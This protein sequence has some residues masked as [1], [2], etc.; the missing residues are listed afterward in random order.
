MILLNFSHQ[1]SSSQFDKIERLLSTNIDEVISISPQI[2]IKEHFMEQIHK[3]VDEVGFSLSDWQTKPIL[4][5][6]PSYNLV[7]L[8]LI[9]ILHG[10]MGYFPAIIR[11]Q[12]V[13]D[14]TPIKYE[15]AEIINL[16]AVRDRVRLQR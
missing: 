7:A 15:V 13:S 6:P 1:I 2:D 11:F 8:V 12:P 5:N 9:V 16:Q 4:I 3:M 10:R 14:S